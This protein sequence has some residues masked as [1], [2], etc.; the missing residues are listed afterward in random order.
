MMKSL[1]GRRAV[2]TG[3]SGGIGSAI[4][5]E[6]ISQGAHVLGLDHAPGGSVPM[7]VCDLAD[8]TKLEQL[9][10]EVIA[11]IGEVDI[12]VN[13]AGVFHSESVVD[14]SWVAYDHTLRVNLHAPVF[15]MSRLGRQMADRQYGRI[16]NV[17]SIHA[18][19]SEPMSTA[20][21][22]SKAGLEA[23]TRTF[24]IELGSF[25]VL[26]NSVAPG[27]VTGGMSVVDGVDELQSDW[28]RSIYIEH[29]RLPLRRSAMPAE[30]ATCVAFLCSEANTYLTGQSITVDG[31][32]SARF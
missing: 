29:G 3:T 27:F 11:K 2:V 4:A 22:V 16:V 13:C 7:L 9:T 14:L 28:F 12:L 10:S 1:E 6:F 23:A 32:L 8:T 19:L 18:R 15:L 25:G 31:G 20:Y 5:A 24:A 21:D 26:A 17:T 30:I